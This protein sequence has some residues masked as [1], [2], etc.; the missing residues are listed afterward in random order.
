MRW[1][2]GTTH[3]LTWNN[4]ENIFEGWRRPIFQK[5]GFWIWKNLIQFTDLFLNPQYIFSL[6][7]AYEFIFSRS[8]LF[9]IILLM[10]SVDHHWGLVDMI[11]LLVNW[12]ISIFWGGNN[13]PR[14]I[15]SQ[16]TKRIV[17]SME[18]YWWSTLYWLNTISKEISLHFFFHQY[19]HS[20][21][22]K[23]NLQKP[24]DCSNRLKLFNSEFVFFITVFSNIWLY[25][26]VTK[27]K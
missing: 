3:T 12:K 18:P 7:D 2:I 17:A 10:Y 4:C 27:Q 14:I 9:N 15:I 5:L 6:S 16:R 1:W 25:F 20:N 8:I 11:I 22:Q 13:N 24:K 23:C 21:C 19:F 26:T